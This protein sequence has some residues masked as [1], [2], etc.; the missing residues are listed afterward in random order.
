M[1]VQVF[2][3]LHTA[4]VVD[5]EIGR[6]GYETVMWI[7]SPDMRAIG[8]GQKWCG[9]GKGK[10]TFGDYG[11][12][13]RKL[14][15]KEVLIEAP[16]GGSQI[17][18]RVLEQTAHGIYVCVD[19]QGLNARSGHIQRMRPLERKDANALLQSRESWKELDGCPAI[20]GGDTTS[21]Y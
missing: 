9:F 5:L 18:I 20:G 8:S 10:K 11:Y 16:H 6:K 4:G 17:A 13:T 7:D 1:S 14:D 21:Q 12:V 15:E 19:A 2:S 3:G